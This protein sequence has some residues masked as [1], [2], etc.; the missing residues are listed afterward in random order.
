MS[1]LTVIV[2]VAPEGSV[3]YFKA[4]ADKMG[5]MAKISDSYRL[6][7]IPG[8]FHCGGG[9][10]TSTFNMVAA[11]DT[12]VADKKAPDSIPASRVRN[13][14]TDR[15]RPLCPYPQVAMYKGVGST[16]SAVNFAC[17]AP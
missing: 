1:G 11:L 6:F 7:M 3:N 5:G 13:G 4:V 14:Q 2:S 8:M 9:D 12:W 16:D 15:T 10:G 17:K